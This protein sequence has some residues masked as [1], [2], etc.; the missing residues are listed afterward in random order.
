MVIN[1]AFKKATRRIT[2]VATSVVMASSAVF[3][4]GLSN[5][6]DNF[7]NTGVN[8]VVGA[9]AQASDSTAANMII[10]SLKT[11]S[12]KYEVTYIKST[13]GGGGDTV[14]AVR[15]N[16]ELNYGEY[17][18]DFFDKKYL[19]R[20]DYSPDGELAKL[21]PTDYNNDDPELSVDVDSKGFVLHA[22]SGNKIPII[23]DGVTETSG[24]DESD[25]DVL[26]DK[27]FDNDISDEDY[28]QKLE[29]LGGEFNYALRDEVDGVEEITSGIFYKDGDIFASYTLEMNSPI[30]LDED[31]FDDDLIGH[32]L[33]IMGNEF[34]IAD[35]TRNGKKDDEN[36]NVTKLVL[37]GGSQRYALPEGGSISV[38][39]GGRTYEIT[40]LNIDD[41]EVLLE[42]DGDA[43]SIDEYDSEDVS[44]LV[45]AV[46]DLVSGSQHTKGNAVLV[47]GGNKV[48]LE[49]GRVK[50]N[51]EDFSDMYE[52]EYDINV[53]FSGE[54]LETITID[55]IVD[56][57][58]LLQEGDSLTDV[59]FDAFEVVYEG[60]NEPDYSELKLEANDDDI[61]IFGETDEGES[62][63]KS[64][65]HAN[66]LKDSEKVITGVHLYVVGNNDD[67][68][69]FFRGSLP[70]IPGFVNTADGDIVDLMNDN[71]AFKLSD[72]EG[73]GFLLGDKN[74]AFLYEIGK[75]GDAEEYETH[76]NELLRGNDVDNL[77][78]ADW[79]E[80]LGRGAPFSTVIDDRG[81]ITLD[82]RKLGNEIPFEN[83]MVLELTEEA[84]NV[85][86][87]A[88]AP[89][90]SKLTFKLDKGDVNYDK[91]NDVDMNIT[92]PIIWNSDDEL[93]FNTPQ[94]EG[95]EDK[96]VNAD[97]ADN[98]EDSDFKT[99]V[100]KYGVMV[101]VNDDNDKITIMT[102]D[103][104]VR[105]EVSV[106]FGDSAKT[107]F[108]S[109]S[110]MTMEEAEERADELKGESMYKN[111]EVN[112]MREGAVTFAISG[113]LLDSQV[114]GTSNMIVVGG[115][116]VNRVAAQLLSLPYPSVGVASGLSPG[117]GQIRLFESV[118]SVLVYGWSAADT[119]AAASRL[120]SGNLEGS[121][122]NVG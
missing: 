102:P 34:T 79:A 3:G 94:L 97:N 48:T 91:P 100:T 78:L 56:D 54:G 43:Q 49:K 53:E 26:K 111:V 31:K 25:T 6:P 89:A 29:L 36:R 42:V 83:E 77:P 4:A 68:R 27:R 82:T 84:E 19:H 67:N 23:T 113:P 105:A 24:F 116:A 120:S 35:I 11:E 28:E 85:N 87:L 60:T 65:L 114:I 32:E 98:D 13:G 38:P 8:V 9:A 30:S 7:N 103:E 109:E 86:F 93:E 50:I 59:L 15:S 41:D 20:D 92:I 95:D 10:D 63:S 73:F 57:H 55:Y 58:F 66:V 104:Q 44:G 2:A 121:Q 90:S 62:L 40:V 118:N 22:P 101:E 99:F 16:T 52:G 81:E 14:D 70:D 115:P 75:V 117:Q 72:S 112:D 47:V 74:D 18:G 110:F 37:T 76:F 69:I 21:F 33:E 119:S 51:N 39:F 45:I 1:R 17:L 96:W 108:M 107:E 106:V 80:D 88:V 122:V 46:T 5:Y 12:M 71:V 61:E 64:L